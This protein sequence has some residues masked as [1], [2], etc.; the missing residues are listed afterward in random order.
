MKRGFFFSISYINHLSPL[1]RR[2]YLKD[3]FLRLLA[4][5]F[6][7]LNK[8]LQTAAYPKPTRIGIAV[9]PTSL[10]TYLLPP[11]LLTSLS[12]SLHYAQ[13]NALD[14]RLAQAAPDWYCCHSYQIGRAHD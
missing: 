5:L 12:L 2:K 14:S 6:I 9:T 3:C 10:F 13:Q 11:P 7:M 4:S 1:L 8:T